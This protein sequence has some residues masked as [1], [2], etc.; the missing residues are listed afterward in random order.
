[1]AAAYVAAGFNHFWHP[2]TYLAI[3]PPWLPAPNTFVLVS[4]IC[5]IVLGLLLI[6]RFSRRWAAWGIILLLIVVFPANIQMFINYAKADH[7]KTWLT[8]L[9][10]PLQAAF[11]GWA[12]QYTR[13]RELK[14]IK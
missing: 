2:Q 6:P 5:E 7:S 1:M 11:I 4:G 13:K 14:M 10:L 3:M 9:R 8:L 12:Y